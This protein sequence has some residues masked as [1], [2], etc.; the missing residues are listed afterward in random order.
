MASIKIIWVILFVAF[1]SVSCIELERESAHYEFEVVAETQFEKTSIDASIK[2]L[3]Q[4]IKG[5][6]NFGLEIEHSLESSIC[7]VGNQILADGGILLISEMNDSTFE[8]GGGEIIFPPSYEDSIFIMV[9]PKQ[10]ILLPLYFSDYPIVPTVAPKGGEVIYRANYTF[11][12]C[13]EIPIMA[14]KWNETR[15]NTFF[16]EVKSSAN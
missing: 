10:K 15:K 2:P 7:L 14:E 11:D 12:D 5:K 6:P 9:L 4:N 3:D 8:N 13:D 1:L 16:V